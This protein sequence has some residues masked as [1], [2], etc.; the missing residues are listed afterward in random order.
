[1]R[2]QARNLIKQLVVRFA[3]DPAGW[4]LTRATF[5]HD[6]P[7]MTGQAGFVIVPEKG[8]MERT[9]RGYVQHSPQPAL[10]ETRMATLPIGTNAIYENGPA[11][12]SAMPSAYGGEVFA[13]ARY[14]A[15]AMKQAMR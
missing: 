3:G 15:L 4:A 2:P 9:F 5:D 12:Y 7:G 13:D 6:A 1:M 8:S 11:D 10:A 14:R